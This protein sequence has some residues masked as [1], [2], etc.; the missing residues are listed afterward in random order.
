MVAHGNSDSLS[1]K[2]SSAQ[3]RCLHAVREMLLSGQAGTDGNEGNPTVLSQGVL[4]S[5]LWN[6][7]GGRPAFIAG[8]ARVPF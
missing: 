3:P 8:H 1:E 5:C 4:A 6:A 7:R 2:L